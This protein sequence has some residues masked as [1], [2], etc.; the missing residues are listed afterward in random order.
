M[1]KY[2]TLVVIVLLTKITLAGSVDM[3]T[4]GCDNGMSQ[5]FTVGDV[6][7]TNVEQV[8]IY[9]Q[10][11]GTVLHTLPD[12]IFFSVIDGPVC[13][14]NETTWW[15]I[16]TDA[17]NDPQSI[18]PFNAIGWAMET[19]QDE[20]QLTAYEIIDELFQTEVELDI[21]VTA[22]NPAEQL[23]YGG[24]AGGGGGFQGCR[25]FEHH[26]IV[27]PRW[28][29]F[30]GFT[31]FHAPANSARLEERLD[32]WRDYYE[33]NSFE[34]EEQ[35][36]VQYLRP[37]GSIAWQM[38]T[39][40]VYNQECDFSYVDISEIKSFEVNPEDMTLG[41][42]TLRLQGDTGTIVEHS[43]YYV[44]YP[45][46][47]ILSYCN[48]HEY[49]LLIDGMVPGENLE[50]GLVENVRIGW[51][52]L[53][54][55]LVHRWDIQVDNQ[56]QLKLT[57]DDRIIRSDIR[58]I[59]VSDSKGT[60]IG[61]RGFSYYMETVEEADQMNLPSVPFLDCRE[62]IDDPNTSVVEVN[63]PFIGI[64]SD[65]A[66]T[67]NDS[68]APEVGFIGNAGDVVD[69]TLEDFV[70]VGA[71]PFLALVSPSGEII[72][73]NDNAEN[74]SIVNEV[75][76]AHIAEFELPET[77]RYIVR[78][79]AV[80][81]DTEH[82]V[83]RILSTDN[84]NSPTTVVDGPVTRLPLGRHEARQF[85]SIWS[86]ARYQD[87]QTPSHESYSISIGRDMPITLTFTWCADTELR[88]QEILEPLSVDFSV[89]GNPI[90]DMSVL[91][92]NTGTC[93]IWD[94]IIQDWYDD[95][96]LPVEIRYQIET[97]I[98][99]GYTTYEDG[100]YVHTINIEG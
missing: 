35:V 21:P 24:A 74:Q 71:D 5:Q 51:Q 15:Q 56:G 68:V 28:R 66:F 25:F 99:D 36:D 47:F 29:Y 64:P 3:Q 19:Q 34:A 60:F 40:A 2:L 93:R 22:V 9:D 59:M 41:E 18:V 49:T 98:F 76:D 27:S 86:Y 38:S 81:G 80:T 31:R 32:R 44:Q 75:Y 55:H 83:L 30:H 77:G 58:S 39:A 48:E 13:T 70:G 61:Y 37:D 88:L 62:S 63:V 73:T 92:T 91:V 50:I 6:G 1:W 78:S 14:N 10:P 8:R 84:T 26:Q 4:G 69:I 100:I 52:E 45:Y 33:I 96:P 53:H 65:L 42:W 95:V 23:A 94:T 79:S 67:P 43:M 89:G 17:L 72:A 54:R 16:E 87:S 12:Q 82:F 46:P 7:L 11:D 85:E 97:P 90:S 20:Y 57:F